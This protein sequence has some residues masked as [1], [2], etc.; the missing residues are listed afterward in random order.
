MRTPSIITSCLGLF[1]I[2]SL[3]LDSPI[4]IKTEAQHQ[5]AQTSSR[6]CAPIAASNEGTATGETDAFDTQIAGFLN[7]VNAVAGLAISVVHHDRVIYARGFGYQELEK[8]TPVT[9][10]TRFYLKSTTK[11]FLGVLAAQLHEEGVIELD[12]PI[13]EYLPNLAPP[14]VNAA[15]LTIRH[16]LTHGI[17]YFDGG[18]NFKSAFIGMEES[19]YIPHVNTYSRAKDTRFQYSNFGPIIAAHAIGKAAKSNWRALI[20]N[21]VFAPL[22]MHNSFTYMSK[23]INGPMATAY[24]FNQQGNLEAT[25]TKVDAQMHAAG[26]SV[27]TVDDLSRWLIASLNDGKLGGQQAL[28]ASAFQQAHARQINMDWTY[29][30]FRRFAHGFGHYSADYEGDL[31]MHHFGGETHVSFMPE[32]NIGIAVLSNQMQGGAL[33][34]HRIAALIYDILLEKENMEGRWM[35]AKKEIMDAVSN[36]PARQLSHIEQLKESVSDSGPKIDP[37]RL[38]GRYNNE[39]IGDIS[40]TLDTNQIRMRYGVLDGTLEHIEGNAYIARFMPWGGEAVLF[41]FNQ[42]IVSKE[43]SIDWG[44]R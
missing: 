17:P 16:H 32:H 24:V 34:T 8:C 35:E 3:L 28:A 4:P 40:I 14:G 13:T 7:E 31:L 29:Y 19:A 23:A 21:K 9:P 26:G 12:A 43:I 27:S 44:G 36:M 2:V 39:R 42:D 22:G 5:S 18:L 38:A 33:T 1:V 41:R 30:K 10:D 15:Q 37:S 6:T 11:S 20:E 25:Q